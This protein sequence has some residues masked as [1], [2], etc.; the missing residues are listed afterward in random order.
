[1]LTNEFFR[2][3]EQSLKRIAKDITQPSVTMRFYGFLV[4]A[5][6]IHL[7]LI[8]VFG[9]FLCRTKH[10][11]RPVAT[12]AITISINDLLA[13]TNNSYTPHHTQKSVF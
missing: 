6:G 7:C 1:M 3:T 12:N 13:K 5:E 11:A 10:T 4:K 2:I 8:F 9:L